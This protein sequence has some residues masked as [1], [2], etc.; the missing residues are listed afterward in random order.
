MKIQDRPSP[1]HNARPSG[2]IIDTLLLHADASPTMAATLAWMTVKQNDP[3][4]RVSYHDAIGRLGD[5]YHL[6]DHRRRAWHA[7]ASEYRGRNDV[8]DYSIG[9]CFSNRNDGVEPYR[10]AQLEAGVELCVSIMRAWPA[11][12]LDRVTTHALVAE[13]VGRKTDPKAF[14]LADFLLEIRSRL[15][16]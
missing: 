14:P 8:N 3:K 6:V 7:G 11:I 10:D 4:N 15:T 1:N 13:P 2:I 9:V 16:T 5:V 12:T